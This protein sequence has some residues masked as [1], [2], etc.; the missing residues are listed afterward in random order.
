M[1]RLYTG[2]TGTMKTLLMTRWA[3]GQW[4][5]GAKILSNYRLFFSEKNERIRYFSN[6]EEIYSFK[7]G[8]ILIDEAQ[9]LLDS[10]CWQDLPEN[11]SYKITQHRKHGL[12][13]CATTQHIGMI[14]IRARQ[15]VQDWTHCEKVLRFPFNDRAKTIFQ[16]SR[17]NKLTAQSNDDGKFSASKSRLRFHFIHCKQKALYNTYFDIGMSN[18]DVKIEH[19]EGKTKILV[20]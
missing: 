19:D 3:Y 10:R 20:R 16:I 13:F 11:F 9:V 7:D 6:L 18:L 2:K 1:F 15:L 17:T 4:K 5:K 14:D 12:D 8:I